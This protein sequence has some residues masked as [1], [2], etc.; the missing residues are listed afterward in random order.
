MRLTI[1]SSL[2]CVVGSIQAIM[3]LSFIGHL[4]DPAMMSGVGLGNM[5]NNLCALSIILGFN[6]ALDTLISQAAGAGNIELSGVY[7][8]QG[9]FIMTC[10]FIPIAGV[11]M[12]T[13]T[14]LVAAGQDPEVAGY[15]QA[16]VLTYLPGLYFQCLD[17]LQRKFLNNFK[18][19][20]F[21]FICTC[22][23]A[24]FHG[25]WCYIF[26]IRCNYGI[27]GIGVANL[28]S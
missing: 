1:P 10:V 27:T 23:G 24:L 25:L 26:V 3:N 21:A 28:I 9:R 7:L 4:N 12:N 22:F 5:T 20:K 11:L 8:N 15:A 14:L 16:Y 6:S 19:N 18:K 13:K 2:A 17:D